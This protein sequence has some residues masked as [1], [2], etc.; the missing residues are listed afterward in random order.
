MFDE[1]E[2]EFIETPARRFVLA[3][4]PVLLLGGATDVTRAV[5]NFLE[6]CTA[7]AAGHANFRIGQAEFAAAVHDELESLP[8]TEDTGG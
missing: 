5:A 3:D 2:E 8:T 7:V 6:N 1:E 4:I